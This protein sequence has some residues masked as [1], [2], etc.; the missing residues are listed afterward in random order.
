L[1][2]ALAVLLV[3][4]VAGWTLV[5]VLTWRARQKRADVRRVERKLKPDGTPYPPAGPGVCQCCQR[6]SAA[7]YHLPSGQRL[8]SD[9]HGAAH[10]AD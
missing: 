10:P 2:I 4:V 8:C 3:L 7:V 6:A 1:R 9:C 5:K